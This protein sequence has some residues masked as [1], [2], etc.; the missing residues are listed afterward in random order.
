MCFT[1]KS[2]HVSPR[3]EIN[4]PR[5]HLKRRNSIYPS[6]FKVDCPK[7]I[8]K[9]KRRNS[10]HPNK[11]PKKQLLKDNKQKFEEKKHQQQEFTEKFI[12]EIIACGACCENFSLKQNAIKINC[13]SC[14][15]FFHC[16]IAGA[17]VGPNCSVLL[18]GKKESL[19][20]CMDCVNNYL[21][22][23]VKDNGQCLCKECETDPKTDK[24]Y[25]EV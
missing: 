7:S 12:S 18:D 10:P 17:C 5:T 19:K 13:S 20:Y 25:I 9:N 4:S 11:I 23:N 16:S 8:L 6:N 2:I 15:K 24:I 21:K 14:N 1:K 3:S 22:I